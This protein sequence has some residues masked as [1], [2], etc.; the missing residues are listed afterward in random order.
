MPGVRALA[1]A[2]LLCALF[3]WPAVSA[4]AE[5]QVPAIIGDNMV[6]QAGIKVRIWGKANPGERVT[7]LFNS[8]TAQATAD[9]QGRWQTFIG[10]LTA[11][12]PFALTIKGTNTLTFKNVLVE[13]FGFVPASQIWS[14]R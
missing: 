14:G 4:Q 9:Q 5:V 2:L 7:V 10:P 13:R 11:G 12:G 6:L 1:F 3:I 8:K